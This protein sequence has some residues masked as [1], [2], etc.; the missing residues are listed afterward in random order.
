[1]T[2][3][4]ACANRLQ[5]WLGSATRPTTAAPMPLV[6][7]VVTSGSAPP[8]RRAIA[9]DAAQHAAAQRQPAAEHRGA[10][11]ACRLDVARAQHGDHAEPDQRARDFGPSDAQVKDQQTGHHDD[12]RPG[13]RHQRR[14]ARWQKAERQRRQ[15][16]R[17]GIAEHPE[18][19]ACPARSGWREFVS[20]APCSARDRRAARPESTLPAVRVVVRDTQDRAAAPRRA[21]A[22]VD[23][24]AGCPGSARTAVRSAR[25]TEALRRLDA[26]NAVAPRT[27]PH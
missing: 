16:A 14:D 1:M 8:R 11:I 13:V 24:P 15:A 2:G 3:A 7:A 23:C 22:R 27:H 21:S 20:P 10:T 12:Q 4:D 9:V 17:A 5:S 25:C 26:P 18:R 6:S 19:S